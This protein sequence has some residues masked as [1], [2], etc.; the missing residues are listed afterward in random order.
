MHKSLTGLLLL[1]GSPLL[2]N[3]EPLTTSE[4]PY[5]VKLYGGASLLG[6]QDFNQQGVA[7]VAAGATGKGSFDAGWGF[8]GALG[9]NLTNNFSTEVAWDYFT[10]G[11]KAT[12]SDG[13]RFDGDGDFSS[14]IIFLNG[15][16]KFDPV[17]T[18][19]IR[20]YVGAGVA[21]VDEI[22]FDTKRNGVETSYS[23]DGEF[24]WQ[25]LAGAEYPL[26]DRWSLNADARYINAG[27][28][29]LKN[30]AG[31]GTI[32]NIDYNISSLML[33]VSYKF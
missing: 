26:N 13:T 30:E 17:T 14:S 8:G 20:P 22:D 11:A 12:F 6:D 21:Y 15:I 27:S 5:Y 16:Y 31:T 33:G 3:A 28:Q 7:G 29:D 9:Y 19:R 25:V 24:A 32:R 10:N 18:H 4:K 2:V 1:A 23:T